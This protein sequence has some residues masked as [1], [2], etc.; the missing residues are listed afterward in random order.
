MGKIF[1]DSLYS[2]IKLEKYTP[3]P[4]KK[5]GKLGLDSKKKGEASCREKICGGFQETR[6]R[7]V[8][9][10]YKWVCIVLKIMSKW[11]SSQWK[12]Q[13]TYIYDCTANIH[14]RS[15]L[16]DHLISHVFQA[17]IGFHYVNMGE[18]HNN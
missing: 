1:P 7:A 18:Y 5:K 15:N 3:P 16:T 14:V 17:L 11:T 8:D 2:V 10:V 13:I 12:I 9:Y 4:K 6:Q